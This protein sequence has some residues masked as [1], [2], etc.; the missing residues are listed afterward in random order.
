GRDYYVGI[1]N[2]S[3]SPQQVHYAFSELGLAGGSYRL[4]DLWER[5][6]LGAAKAIEVSL[7]AHASV[8]YRVSP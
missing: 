2:L 7:P 8:L 4:R 6:N 3:D 5:R 1:F